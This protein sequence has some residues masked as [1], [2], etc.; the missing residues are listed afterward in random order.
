[1][2]LIQQRLQARQEKNW[3]EADRIRDELEQ[4]GILLEDGAAGT[5]W[6]RS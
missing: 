5:S 2:T 3:A 1:M 4:Q 6:R